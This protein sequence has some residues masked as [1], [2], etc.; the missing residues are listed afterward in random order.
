ME[1]VM[2][3]KIIEA[4][5]LSV[6]DCIDN[7]RLILINRD[8]NTETML[9]LGFTKINVFEE[10]RKLEYTDYSSGPERD[11]DKKFEGE[12]WIFG[13]EIKGLEIYIKFKLKDHCCPRKFILLII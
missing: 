9:K 6:R 7:K 12:F 2:I 1:I 4:I 10:I 8:K 11:R 3:E 13:K 5:L